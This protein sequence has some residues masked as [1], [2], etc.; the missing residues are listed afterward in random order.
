MTFEEC[1]SDVSSKNMMYINVS[2]DAQQSHF[3]MILLKFMK[4][5]RNLVFIQESFLSYI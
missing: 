1:F 5:N 4:H 3:N 2:N